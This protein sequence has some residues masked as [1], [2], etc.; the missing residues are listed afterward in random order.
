MPVHDLGYRAWDGQ[1]Q[2]RRA[3][4]WAIA[5][6]GIRLAW[7]NRYLR[8]LLLV[9]WLPALY[10]GTAFL[11][12][13]QWLTQYE[14]QHAAIARARQSVERRAREGF[15]RGGAAGALVEATGALREE[16]IRGADEG[17]RHFPAN[18]ARHQL[19]RLI[20]GLPIID[21]RGQVWAW[22]LM[23]FFRHPQGLVLLLV[24]GLIAP[25]LISRDIGARAFL[26]Y[27][28]RP[29]GRMEYVVGKLAIV[30]TY[31]LMISTF[32]ALV[33]YVLG[34]LLSP[35]LSVVNDTWDLPLRILAASAVLLIPT[36][37]LALAISSL[38][39]RTWQA[40]FAWFA[41]WILGF[42]AYV[43]MLASLAGQMDPHWVLISL[44]HT[45]G[46]VQSWVF[47]L[48]PAS[49][50]VYW[51]V[52]LLVAITVVSLSITFRRISSPL[53]T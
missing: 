52:A 14:Q 15:E 37:T 41:G 7:Q 45:L 35:R 32:P 12:Y 40:S 48:E 39:T 26:L 29:I 50:H 19:S 11:L 47:G 34:V 2:P 42:A 4:W 3:R 21:D 36:T 1:L 31:V 46:K 27:F 23:T 24:V 20:P 53:R 6:T 22:L 28:S 5:D 17:L 25:P 10:M 49:S 30:W 43:S 51:C 44:Y 18:Q 38:T 13:E 33:L 16:G 8:R 9:A